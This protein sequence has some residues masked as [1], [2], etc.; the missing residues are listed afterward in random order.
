VVPEEA[1][2]PLGGKQYVYKVVD[3]P[4]AG[5]ASRADNGGGAKVSQRVEARLGVRLPGKVEILQGI[6]P[7]DLVVTAGHQRLQRGEALPLRI[8]DLARAG[9]GAA[10]GAKGGAKKPE[11]AGSAP[12]AGA[13]A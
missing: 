12:R 13:P 3:A 4:A 1:V 7:G 2:V 8:I 6:A 5:A 9:E 10:S 11:G